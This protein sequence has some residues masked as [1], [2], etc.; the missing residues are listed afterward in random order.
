MRHAVG[1]C[2]SEPF[3]L[4]FNLAGLTIPAM[5]I[6]N[7]S[8]VSK[9]VVEV[10][11]DGLLE[12]ANEALVAR[13]GQ[14]PEIRVIEAASIE[15]GVAIDEDGYMLAV[16]HI[17]QDNC[18]NC[19]HAVEINGSYDL[20]DVGCYDGL[21][22]RVSRDQAV[23]WVLHGELPQPKPDIVRAFKGESGEWRTHPYGEAIAGSRSAWDSGS[24]KE[25]SSDSVLRLVDIYLPTDE[26]RRKWVEDA[27]C[28]R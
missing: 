22:C 19:R 3:H 17:R 9:F 15:D 12:L 10:D 27:P 11:Q 4:T 8:E 23:A 2:G 24:G 25:A 5:S 18:P 26:A 28:W 16:G 20:Y 1:I 13:L 21:A 7:V 6:I 14:R